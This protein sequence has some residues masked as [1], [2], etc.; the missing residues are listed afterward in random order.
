L[1]GP[2]WYGK[3]FRFRLAALGFPGF[4]GGGR[5]LDRLFSRFFGIND[6]GSGG[7]FL[8]RF[9]AL[10]NLFIELFLCNIKKYSKTTV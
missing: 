7:V 9:N 2:A 1:S 6:C 10:T 3:L 8:D 5:S 4:G